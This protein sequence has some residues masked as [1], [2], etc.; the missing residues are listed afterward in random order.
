VQAL[1]LVG[2]GENSMSTE[3]NETTEQ[4]EEKKHPDIAMSPVESSQLH[5]IGHDSATNTLAIQFKNKSGPSGVYHYANF[6]PEQ[7][8]EFS[9]AESTGAHFGKFIKTETEK[10]PFIKVS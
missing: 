7:F 9:G 4:T 8:A 1:V 2:N 10:H 6:T 3:I 5:A